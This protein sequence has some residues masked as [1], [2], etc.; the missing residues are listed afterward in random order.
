MTKDNV[1]MIGSK[2]LDSDF[3]PS[4]AEQIPLL[5]A[6]TPRIH[7]KLNDL[8]SKGQEF[9]DFC[10]SINQPLLP[11][12]EWLAI[13]AHKVKPDGRWAHPLVVCVQARQN[14]KT[15]LMKNRI[16]MGLF[17]WKDRLQIGTAH[18]LTT[19]LETFRDLV[20]TIESNEALA[21]Q[22]KRVRWAHGSEEIETLDGCRYMVKAGASA[23]RGISKPETVF[24]DEVRELKDETTWASLRYTMMASDH[25][26]LWA[27]SNAGD[28]HSVVLNLLKDRGMAAAGGGTTDDIFYAE[29]SGHTDE[30]NN[31][32]NWIAAN[33]ALGRTIHID[34]IKSALNDPPDVFR[35][36]VLSRWV[37]TISS[38]IQAAEWE[39]CGEDDIDLSLNEATWFGLDCSPDRRH[40]ALV[41]AQKMSD[42]RFI[43][44]LLHTWSN[45]ISLDHLSMANDISHY[46]RKYPYEILAYSK[47]TASGVAARLSPAG[48]LTTD[49]D[50]GLYGQACDEFLSSVTSKRLRHPKQ[51]EFTKQV[52]SAARLPYGDGAWIITR[53]ATN[54]VVTASVAAAL[55]TH[56][57]TR[58]KTE[59]DILIG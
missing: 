32:A 24:M 22:V 58:P 6:T 39:A 41:G 28:Q 49:I 56:F 54:T 27:L 3:K 42:D 53:K 35:T 19:S 38:A 40:A 52:L 43:V 29:W 47:R 55:A 36:E 50:G 7:S 13:Q 5:G 44:K 9:I 12:Q 51:A 8:P 2:R 20:S 4:F 57:A 46:L 34:N 30:I 17:E 26:Q 1:V 48:F 31:E 23:A 25:P 33:P 21:K 59:I 11:H 10:N 16:L 45:P 18:R 14:G 37:A 15:Y